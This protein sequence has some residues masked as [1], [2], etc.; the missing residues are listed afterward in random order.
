M[1]M[2]LIVTS[3]RLEYN[4]SRSKYPDKQWEQATE[5]F[6]GRWEYFTPYKVAGRL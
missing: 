6:A 4:A 3:R 2:D 1:M 5:R